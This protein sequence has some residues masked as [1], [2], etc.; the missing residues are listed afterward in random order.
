MYLDR[1]KK[2]Y[3]RALAHLWHVP[4][5]MADIYGNNAVHLEIASTPYWL[6]AILHAF[7]LKRV[8]VVL[9]RFANWSNVDEAYRFDFDGA[10]LIE[11]SC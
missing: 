8:R 3:A 10:L 1:V 5:C 11:D 9:P 4:S 2:E 7:S 6:F